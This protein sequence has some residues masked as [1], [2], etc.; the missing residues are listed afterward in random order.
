ME[1]LYNTPPFLII[2]PLGLLIGIVL[3]VTV[4]DKKNSDS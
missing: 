2:I 3:I 4:K 1:I